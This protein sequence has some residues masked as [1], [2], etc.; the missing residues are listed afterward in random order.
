MLPND[1]LCWGQVGPLCSSHMGGALP[2]SFP[3]SLDLCSQPLLEPE[4]WGV[5][6]DSSLSLAL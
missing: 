3:V 5:I 1:Q 2:V 4:T 6:P